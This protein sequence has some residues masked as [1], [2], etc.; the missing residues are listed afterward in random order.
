MDFNLNGR[1]VSTEVEP[2]ATLLELLRE[3]FGLRSMKDGCAPEGTCG[4]CT[5][6]VDGR[7][8]VSCARA[9]ERVAGRDVVTSRAAGGR[10]GGL[11]RGV[12][13]GGRVPVRFC[14]PGIVMKAEGSWPARH[15][16]PGRMPGLAATSAVHRYVKSSALEVRR[17]SGDAGRGAPA[18]LGRRR[19]RPRVRVARRRWPSRATVRGDMTV[20]ACSTAPRSATPRLAAGSSLPRPAA[21]GV[22]AS[23]RGR[24]AGIVSSAIAL[25][26]RP[27]RR[28][29]ITRYVA[30]SWPRCGPHRARPGTAA[31]DVE[32][33]SWTPSRPFAAWPRR[34]PLHARAT[35]WRP[36]RASRRRRRSPCR[37]AH[38]EPSASPP[39][40]REL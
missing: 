4:A 12:H 21:P 35:C 13:G 34:A 10:P 25:L 6:L 28:G 5:V 8:V 7:P 2:G 27:R 9:A 19:R 39:R 20:P 3:G 15:A 23:S 24:R 26:P 32:Y 38:C 18:S 17:P 16:V 22:V 14:S 30:T 40:G 11:G 31:Y 33:T 29:E 1:P 37:R 36:R